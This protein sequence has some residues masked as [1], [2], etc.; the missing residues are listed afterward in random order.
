MLAALLFV[1]RRWAW[2]TVQVALLLGALEW[3]RTILELTEERAL[4][5]IPSGRMVAILG[6]VAAVCALAA[7]LLFAPRV[8]RWFGAAWEGPAA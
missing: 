1:R 2:R 3:A 4:M 5:G 7:L 8:R 6:A